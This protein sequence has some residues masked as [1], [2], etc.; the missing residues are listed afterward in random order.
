MVLAGKRLWVADTKE[1]EILGYSLTN[2][3]IVSSIR[4][5]ESPVDIA[6]NR[7]K[8]LYAL[9]G[10]TKLLFRF[11]RHG[12]FLGKFGKER[13]Q[14]PVSVS[15]GKGDVI[16]VV[17]RGTGGFLKFSKEGDSLGAGRFSGST[18][19]PVILIGDAEG[20]GFMLTDSGEV[21]RFDEYGISSGKV[22]FPEDAG[23]V[24]WIATDRCGN[25]YASTESGLYILDSGKTFTKGEGVLL[26]EDARQRH[27]RMPVAQACPA[28]RKCL[29]DTAADI[30]S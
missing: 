2:F 8:D 21:Y 14:E 13:L 7:L 30:Y 19:T 28:G 16:Y 23:P 20:G 27:R 29:Q 1:G 12:S 26:F 5:L 11:D 22:R 18:G 3:Q 4:L 6:V 9:D 24:I 10:E 25:L 17:D 15:V